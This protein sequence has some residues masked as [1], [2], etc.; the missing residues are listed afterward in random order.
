[1]GRAPLA[2]VFFGKAVVII[3][4]CRGRA[5]NRKI[6]LVV[7]GSLVMGFQAA[8]LGLASFTDH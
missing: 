5:M 4:T 1:L 7:L 3:K 6:A 8:A 2:L